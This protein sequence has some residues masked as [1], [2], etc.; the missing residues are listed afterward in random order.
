VSVSIS[1]CLS[2]RRGV[3]SRTGL[4]LRADLL[5]SSRLLLS[6]S[7]LPP[8][9]TIA[10]PS[11]LL[12]QILS[13]SHHRTYPTYTPTRTL[14]LF[15]TRLSLLS[16]ER[17]LLLELEV[18]DALGE[19]ETLNGTRPFSKAMMARDMAAVKTGGASFGGGAAWG[20][21][22]GNTGGRKEGAEVVKAIYEGVWEKWKEEVKIGKEIGMEKRGARAVGDRFQ[23][24]KSC[25]SSSRGP[26]RLSSLTFVLP[27]FPCRRSHPHPNHLER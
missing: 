15:P 12:P 3:D 11:L 1:S 22:F 10:P 23:P 6:A 7:L 25:P 27:F 9:S 19:Q 16:Y 5:S 17:A 24:G 14:S 18:D 13:K 26:A 21:G 8:L 2:C 4:E 20:S